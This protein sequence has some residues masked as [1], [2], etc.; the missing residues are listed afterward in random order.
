M[1]I[2]LDVVRTTLSLRVR[3]R[4]K[5]QGPFRMNTRAGSNDGHSNRGTGPVFGTLAHREDLPPRV[6]KLLHGSFALACDYFDGSVPKAVDEIENALFALADRADT[7]SAQQRHF[8]ALREIKRGRADIAPRFL[9]HVEATLAALRPAAASRQASPKANEDGERIS[10]ELIDPS[11]FDEDLALHEMAAKLEIRHSQALYLL[12]H[13]MAVIGGTPIWPIE[14]LPFGPTQLVAAFRHAMHGLDIPTDARV[15][16]YGHFDRL[17][18]LPIEAFYGAMNLYLTEQRVLPN[19][20]FQTS[21]RRSDASRGKTREPIDPDQSESSAAPTP[22]PPAQH[23]KDDRAGTMTASDTVM[24]ST[25]RQLLGERRRRE[26]EDYP[27]Y[28]NHAAANSSDL[29]SVLGSL[30]RSVYPPGS[31]PIQHDSE[32]LKN[33]LLVK[34]RRSGP[35]GQA[36]RLSEEDADTVDLIGMLFDQIADELPDSDHARALFARLHVPVLRVA[37]NDKTFFARR[38]HPAR[39]LLNTIAETSARWM[40][41]AE[42]DP[43]LVRKMQGVVDHVSANFDGDVSVFETLLSDLSKHMQAVARRAEAAERRHVDAARGRDK[44]DVARETARLEIQRILQGANP[45]RIV[46][47]LLEQAWM[48]A[49]ALSVLRHGADSSEFRSRV[50]AAEMLARQGDEPLENPSLRQELDTGL[51][52]IGWHEDDLPKVLDPVFAAN[53]PTF[54]AC[55]QV[56]DTLA[57]RPRLGGESAKPPLEE[58][59]APIPLSESETAQLEALHKLPFGTWFDFVINQQG[60]TVRR[61]LAW[62]SPATGRCLLVNARGLHA[63]DMS[64]AQLAR[65]IT[66]GQARLVQQEQVTLIDRAWKAILRA[67][68]SNDALAEKVPAGD[69]AV[70]GRPA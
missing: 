16:A 22:E 21:Y 35:K 31:S 30:Q 65:E 40:D 50:A 67:L 62:F 51:R 20:R 10:L 68:H 5:R 49:L 66:R 54:D 38:D 69:R 6:R 3:I 8:E 33:T 53:E 18:M 4:R 57:G 27:E 1:G 43:Q 28:G 60:D 41:D 19:L 37:L 15:F 9:Q 61:K 26:G 59:V 46:R 64:L 56:D 24:F 25:L 32:H 44:L 23:A 47:S 7:N 2:G 58:Q 17:V 55:A 29:Q 14:T 34:L 39:E 11:V 48:D 13:R 63:E 45:N 42:A 52:Q 70:A 12:C 36:L